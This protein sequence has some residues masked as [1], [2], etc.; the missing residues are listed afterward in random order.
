MTKS[1]KDPVGIDLNKFS[2]ENALAGVTPD[3]INTMFPAFRLS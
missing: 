1:M 3:R 2:E